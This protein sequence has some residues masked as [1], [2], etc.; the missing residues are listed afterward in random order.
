[1]SPKK[2]KSEPPNKKYKL[3]QIIEWQN[4][5]LSGSLMQ[6]DLAKRLGVS[7]QRVSLLLL[8]VGGREYDQLKQLQRLVRRRKSTPEIA[9]AL[10]ISPEEAEELRAVF[11]RRRQAGLDSS[12]SGR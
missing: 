9:E 5:V 8:S 11:N 6:K 12:S 4:Q 3:D 1:M 10:G 2:I 7:P